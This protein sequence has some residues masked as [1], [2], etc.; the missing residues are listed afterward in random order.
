MPKN[1]KPIIPNEPWYPAA[2]PPRRP[3]ADR[4]E[5]WYPAALKLIIRMAGDDDRPCFPDPPPPGSDRGC[6]PDAP[7]PRGPR[8]SPRTSRP[9]LQ[10]RDDR[11][12]FP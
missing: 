2:V 1:Q 3:V 11:G 7:R 12:C 5:P 10:R 8:P 9:P 4:K 6:L